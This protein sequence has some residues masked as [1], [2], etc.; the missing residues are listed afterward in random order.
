MPVCSVRPFVL[1]VALVLPLG[2]EPPRAAAQAKEG[3]KVALVVG[4]NRYNHSALPPLRFAERDAADLAEVLRR[5]QYEV[6]TLLGPQATLRAIQQ[7][8]ETEHRRPGGDGIFLVALAGH[9]LQPESSRDPYFAPF[10]AGQRVRRAGDT[11]A[12][13]WDYKS[14]LPLAD[15]I[16]YLKASPA[17]VRMVMVDACRNDDSSGAGRS[18][19]V[20]PGVQVGD[21]PENTAVLLSCSRGQRAY[22]HERWGGGHGAFFYHILEGMRG[23]A[24]D[25]EGRITADDLWKYVKDNVPIEVHNVISPLLHQ[26]PFR[27]VTGDVDLRLDGVAAG[28]IVR[29][30]DAEGALA[31]R[32]CKFIRSRAFAGVSNIIEVSFKDDTRDDEVFASA[33]ELAALPRLRTVDLSGTR[34]GERGLRAVTN[35]RQLV[36]LLL[37][38]TP[39]GNAALR[40]LSGLQGL[41]TLA[42][43]GTAV[44]DAGLREVARLKGLRALRLN[45]TAVSDD[46]LAALAPLERLEVL[47]LKNTPLRGPGLSRL[48]ALKGLQKLFLGGTAVADR[49]VRELQNLRPGLKVIR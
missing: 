46:G 10:D 35:V 23:K 8:L 18:L 31:R 36:E 1:V 40:E 49:D 41:E 39:I 45:S 3:R 43:S 15:V 24:A 11:S 28:G 33:A 12:D 34:V 25:A 6:T 16:A 44:T 20:G 21:L 7:A 37:N 22:E 4:I 42:L 2:A 48:A 17:G 27:L 30:K 14:M 5:G 13:P 9:G 19:G 38:D 32:G 29:V 47:E 26:K